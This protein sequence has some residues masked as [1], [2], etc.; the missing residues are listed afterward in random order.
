MSFSEI[1]G[2]PARWARWLTWAT[3][4][5]LALGL[6]GPFGSYA[7]G[8]VLDRLAYW[9]GLAWVGT[10]ILG[11]TVTPAVR[12][13]CA[14][15]LP[16]SFAAAVATLAG[17]APLAVFAAGVGRRV[18]PDATQGMEP[19]HWY[20]QTVFFAAPLVAT[21]LWVEW[22]NGR[23][24]GPTDPSGIDGAGRT[25]PPPSARLVDNAALPARLRAQTLC[26]QMEDH[27]VRVHTPTGSELVLM[28]MH[29]AIEALGDTE[30]LRVH[31]SWWV[32]RVAVGQVTGEGRALALLLTSGFRV[33]VARN[34]I[35]ELRAKGWL[36]QHAPA[37]PSAP[38]VSAPG[39]K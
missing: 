3:V 33:P 23:N 6:A 10:L 24:R 30:G 21:L 28:P 17:C 34:R 37:E 25:E 22:R 26:L 32:A 36:A 1:V 18:W 11:L 31:R 4:A 20:A 29:W 39:E 19:L 27:Y 35:A 15:G 2:D 5:G 16:P 8:D 7:N 9:V 12:L 13:G 14:V 38:P